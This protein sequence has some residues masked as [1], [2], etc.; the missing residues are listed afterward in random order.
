MHIGNCTRIV[1]F[2]FRIEI[3]K[4]T[5]FDKHMIIFEILEFN[6]RHGEYIL[7]TGK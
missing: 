4:T 3:C 6:E 2:K 5:N 7:V 1:Q